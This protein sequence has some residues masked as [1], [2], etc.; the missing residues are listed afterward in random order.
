MNRSRER[1]VFV[2]LTAIAVAAL[3]ACGEPESATPPPSSAIPT[4]AEATGVYDV[5]GVTVRA[6]DGVLREVSGILRLHIEGEKFSAT[7]E[8]DTTFPDP[9]P[10]ATF[11]AKVAGWGQ[12]MVV[13]D[14][15][16]GTLSS[17]VSRAKPAATPPPA[18][19]P[20]EEVVVLSS[21][22]ARFRP[23]TRLQVELQNHPGINQSYSPTVT[24]IEGKR[25]GDLDSQP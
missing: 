7:Y 4:P 20:V 10:N 2:L 6:A 9:G 15:L 11:P 25:V 8:F 5:H 14:T 23:D 1:F 12:G 13:G 22:T 16:A 19:L 21:L 17:R 24:V 18:R 3:G